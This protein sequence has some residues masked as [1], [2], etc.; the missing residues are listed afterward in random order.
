MPAPGP[1]RVVGV[2]GA[3]A[4][5][6]DRVLDKSRLVQ[7]VGVNRHLHVIFFCHAQTTVDGSWGCAPVLMQL[8]PQGTRLDLFTQRL[9]HGAVALA[10]ES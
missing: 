7:R 2:D 10:E 1:F 6:G 3:T 8:Q 4:E 5:G 9:W